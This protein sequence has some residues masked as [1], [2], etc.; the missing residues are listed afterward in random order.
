MALK[1][2]RRHRKEC[3]A[4]YPEDF[5]NGEFEETRKSW[6]R[7]ACPI[8]A[9][10]TLKDKFKRQSTGHWEWDMAKAVVAQ[11]E[12][13][14]C[15][16]D[17]TPRE[18]VQS[19]GQ[20]AAAPASAPAITIMEATEAFLSRCQ[21]R[22]I[23]PNTFAKYRTFVNQLNTYAQHSGYIRLDQLTVVD[24]DR[25]YASWSDG[26][27]AICSRRNLAPST[28]EMRFS[29]LR[30]LYK[31]T[32]KRKELAF[33]DLIILKVP[34]KLPTV[35]S[36]EEVVRLID[37]APNRLYRVL[38]CLLYAAGA[39]RAE[40]ARIKVQDIFSQRMVPPRQGREGPRCATF[41]QSDR[42][43][44]QLVAMEDASGLPHSQHRG[45]AVNRPAYL[46]Q[47]CLA[48]MP[49]SSNHPA[50]SNDKPIANFLTRSRQRL[51]SNRSIR[52]APR[53]LLLLVTLDSAEQL[54]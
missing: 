24:M 31:R 13:A 44:A 47:D 32:L 52:P 38:L 34:H 10:G 49:G 7:C 43:G 16:G 22:G 14:G 33:E 23:R 15:W 4:G 45:P 30:L 18:T 3:K 11:W 51:P 5:R 36:Q 46:Q 40:A 39:R 6:K 8:H 28:V 54:R 20:P 9:S 26:I 50:K 41:A 1:L 35:L 53:P 19:S 17:P 29:A 37:A 48:R 12:A 21:N 42:G 2:Y 25:F 27:N